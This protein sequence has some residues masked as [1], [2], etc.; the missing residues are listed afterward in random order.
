MNIKT[1]LLSSVVS[2]TSIFTGVESAQAM[3]CFNVPNV[4]ARICNTYEGSNRYGDVYRLG[5]ASDTGS[6]TGM[7]VTCRGSHVVDWNSRGNMNYSYLDTV[8]EYFCSI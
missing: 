5:F 1:L 6:R 8:A 7:S 4:D 2:I 3:T